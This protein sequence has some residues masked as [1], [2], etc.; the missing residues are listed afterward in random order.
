MRIVKSY[1]AFV[2]TIYTSAHDPGPEIRQEKGHKLLT[3]KL[4]EKV[5][6]SGTTSQL[7]RRK[8]LFCWVRRRTHKLFCPV[9]RPV[10]PG[11][12]GPSPEQKVYVYVPFS[13]PGPSVPHREF[14]ECFWALGSECQNTQKALFWVLFASQML[15]AAVCLPSFKTG[16]IA[17]SFSCLIIGP[18]HTYALGGTVATFQVTNGS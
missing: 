14:F 8:W 11:S 12:T 2:A 6:N 1:L 13:L 17:R 7:T 15:L 3:H 4:F 9:S 16:L 5:V 10:V 18:S